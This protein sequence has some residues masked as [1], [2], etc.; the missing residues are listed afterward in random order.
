MIDS[1]DSSSTSSSDS[2]SSSDGSDSSD[3]FF[4]EI[5]TL[6]LLLSEREVK[7]HRLRVAWEAHA[8]H[9]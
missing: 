2:I 7:R 6:S 9:L 8:R 5:C 3:D 4:L 1:S